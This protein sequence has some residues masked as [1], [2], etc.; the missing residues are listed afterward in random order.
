MITQNPETI[1][2]LTSSLRK[3]TNIEPVESIVIRIAERLDRFKGNRIHFDKFWDIHTVVYNHYT[4]FGYDFAYL[5][6]VEIFK[7]VDRA[8]EVDTLEG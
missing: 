8:D 6:T 2:T 7:S 4:D 1:E 3:Y 5:V